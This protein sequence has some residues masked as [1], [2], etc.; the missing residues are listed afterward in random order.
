MV[1]R[2]PRRGVKG[3]AVKVRDN[4][5]EGRLV[6]AQIFQVRDVS[7]MQGMAMERAFVAGPNQPHDPC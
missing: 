1:R 6:D 3:D 7:E 2:S 5:D 4:I